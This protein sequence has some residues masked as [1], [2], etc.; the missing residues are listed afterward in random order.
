MVLWGPLTDL[1][2]TLPRQNVFCLRTGLFV[3][4]FALIC[5]R[6]L[7]IFLSIRYLLGSQQAEVWLWQRREFKSERNIDPGETGLVDIGYMG[8]TK[9]EWRVTV[10]ICNV[11]SAR[12]C[13]SVY[14]QCIQY[15]TLCVVFMYIY[16]TYTL[17]Q[18]GISW[19]K[20]A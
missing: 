11:Y 8:E 7:Y 9:Y 10:F 18:C 20:G 1:K 12:T 5:F 6:H 4:W 2:G 19:A 17:L 3:R 13:Y 15:L 14:N 16:S